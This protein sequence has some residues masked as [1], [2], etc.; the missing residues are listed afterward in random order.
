MVNYH[1]LYTYTIV[2]IVTIVLTPIPNP[3]GKPPNPKDTLIPFVSKGLLPPKKPYNRQHITATPTNNLY[4]YVRLHYSLVH[5]L[6]VLVVWEAQF[7]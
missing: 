7:L 4:I 2:T 1:E 3:K 5:L 6:F